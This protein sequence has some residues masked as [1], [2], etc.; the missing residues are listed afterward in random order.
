MHG[1]RTAMHGNRT[2][3]QTQEP[4]C[5]GTQ[6]HAN[7]GNENGTGKKRF[8]KAGKTREKGAHDELERPARAANLVV[9]ESAVLNIVLVI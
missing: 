3:A 7:T 5:T 4:R 6:G 8:S 9:K 2:G 1:N